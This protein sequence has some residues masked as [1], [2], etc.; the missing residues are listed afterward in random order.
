M[1]L[2][3]L[4]VACTLFIGRQCS[5]SSCSYLRVP[6]VWFNEKSTDFTNFA[7]SVKG[8][9]HE[10]HSTSRHAHRTRPIQHETHARNNQ[11]Q[12]GA[13]A[14]RTNLSTRRHGFHPPRPPS[15]AC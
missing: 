4:D 2:L 8:I 6:G 12:L 14:E 15:T 13:F 11:I 9:A 10:Q 7:R 3:L 1:C 5:R